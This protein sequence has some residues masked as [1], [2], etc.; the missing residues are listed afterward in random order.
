[1]NK[2]EIVGARNKVKKLLAIPTLHF[3]G[4]ICTLLLQ[5]GIIYKAGKYEKKERGTHLDLL[6]TT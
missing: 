3:Q 5:A 6:T 2:E 1:M 4:E